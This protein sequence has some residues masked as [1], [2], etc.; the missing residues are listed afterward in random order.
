MIIDNTQSSTGTK[1]TEDFNKAVSKVNDSK[2]CK[3]ASKP[4]KHEGKCKEIERE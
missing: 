2:F 3:I 1:E 4:P